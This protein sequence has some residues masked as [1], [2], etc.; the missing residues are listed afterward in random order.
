M[1]LITAIIQPV[2][3]HEVQEALSEVGVKG[4]TVTDALGFGNQKGH[5]EHYRGAEY[6]VKFL[7]KKKVEVAVGDDMC[8]KV[9]ETIVQAARTGS[10]GDGKIF[11]HDLQSAVR[12]R[13]GERDADVL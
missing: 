11:I 6:E 9:I 1:K 2:K 3:L 7:P 8:E 12:V 5:T 10:I 13:T 4:I